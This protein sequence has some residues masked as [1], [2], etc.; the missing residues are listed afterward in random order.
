MIDSGRTQKV[1]AIHQPEEV[2]ISLG[3]GLVLW[4]YSV[5]EKHPHGGQTNQDY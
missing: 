1:F 3:Q 4:L 2:S 5:L